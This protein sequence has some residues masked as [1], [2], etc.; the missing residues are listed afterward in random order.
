[1][2]SACNFPPASTIRPDSTAPTRREASPRILTNKSPTF[3]CKGCCCHPQG[4]VPRTSRVRSGTRDAGAGGGL[5]AGGVRRGAK[6]GGVGERERAST[7]GTIF[8]H[9][10]WR[11]R[12]RRQS[13]LATWRTRGPAPARPGCAAVSDLRVCGTRRF[14]EIRELCSHGT[15]R[16]RTSRGRKSRPGRSGLAART[17]VRSSALRAS[18]CS[19]G[20]APT[21]TDAGSL[22]PGSSTGGGSRG[23]NPCDPPCAHPVGPRR[24]GPGQAAGKRCRRMRGCEAE[25]LAPGQRTTCLV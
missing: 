16:E 12:R 6:E 4:G 5:P 11:P 21:T 22:E 18:P 20:G 1:M 15:R 10:L 17:S 13:P 19:E 3:Y 2:P 7:G 25:D 24:A 8:R 14:A 23:C 9:Q